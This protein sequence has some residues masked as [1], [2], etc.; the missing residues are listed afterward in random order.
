MLHTE[1]T[2]IIRHHIFHFFL[3]FISDSVKMVSVI[4]KFS[5]L[6]FGLVCG[7]FVVV[8][9]LFVCS[10]GFFVRFGWLV[11]FVWFLFFGSYASSKL[12]VPALQLTSATDQLV[13]ICTK[14]KNADTFALF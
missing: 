3:P 12:R 14:M 8:G 10:L 11:A 5:E 9:D 1:S 4:V 13:K 6:W 2:A 7:F